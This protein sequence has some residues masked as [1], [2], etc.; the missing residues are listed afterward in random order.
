MRDPLETKITNLRS[1]SR[2]I[3]ETCSAIIFTQFAVYLN[4][5]SIISRKENFQISRMSHQF[6]NNLIHPTDKNIVLEL[7][8]IDGQSEL[9][10]LTFKNASDGTYLC[11][12]QKALQRQNSLCLILN[13]KVANS[14]IR[15]CCCAALSES[16]ISRF[17][18]AAQLGELGPLGRNSREKI[19]KA[20]LQ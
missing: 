8:Y 1:L 15:F 13:D 4:N 6:L 5:R 12:T 7:F 11:I 3:N 9:L 16:S 10:F 14:L 2:S 20:A 17:L 18:A 19:R